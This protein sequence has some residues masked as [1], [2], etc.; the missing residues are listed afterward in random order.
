MSE[1]SLPQLVITII[2][3]DC[4]MLITALQDC[5]RNK[6]VFDIYEITIQMRT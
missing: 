2:L 4:S 1:T 6:I 5:I 3:S